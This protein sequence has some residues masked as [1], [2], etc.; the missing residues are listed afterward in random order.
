[1]AC[2]DARALPKAVNTSVLAL[3]CFLGSFLSWGLK[4]ALLVLAFALGAT[5]A[6][7]YIDRMTSHERFSCD[8]GLR[9][10]SGGGR[11]RG[12]QAGSSRA[13]PCPIK[14]QR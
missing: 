13:L 12:L 14:G 1:M 5:A 10:F 11:R 8:Y 2:S 4:A 3:H 7:S 6:S 9:T